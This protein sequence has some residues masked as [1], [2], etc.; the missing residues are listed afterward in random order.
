MRKKLLVATA[1]L[2]MMSSGL[3]IGLT[4][5]TAAAAP[6]PRSSCVA[7]TI[8][9]EGPP[10]PVLAPAGYFGI[11]GIAQSHTCSMS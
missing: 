10:G 1:A 9:F 11:L 4:A 2:S 7:Q 6:S 8:A 3:V 5:G